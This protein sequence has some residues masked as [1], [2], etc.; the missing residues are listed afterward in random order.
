MLCSKS[1]LNWLHIINFTDIVD[2]YIHL[3]FEKVISHHIQH[4]NY[5]G[6]LH[7]LSKQVGQ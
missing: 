5:T 2:D 4:D 1:V 7:Q 3:D 6:A